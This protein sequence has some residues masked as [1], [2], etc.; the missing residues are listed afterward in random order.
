MAMSERGAKLLADMKAA[1]GYVLPSHEFLAE[2]DPGFLEGYDAFFTAAQRDDSPLPR[3]VREFVLLAADLALGVPA[4]VV[5]SHAKRAMD[6]GATEEEVLA[7]VE[8]TTI[9]YAAKSM[10]IGIPALKDFSK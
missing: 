5:G 1:R 7:V 2:Q 9:A 3:K 6:H 4:N 8:L 10:A